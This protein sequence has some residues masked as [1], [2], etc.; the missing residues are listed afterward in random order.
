MTKINKHFTISLDIVDKLKKIDNASGLIEQLLTEHFKISAPIDEKVINKLKEFKEKKKELS[1]IKKELIHLKEESKLMVNLLRNK[2]KTQEEKDKL[3]YMIEEQIRKRRME[4]R[5]E[6][7]IEFKHSDKLK[8]P[9]F[10]KWLNSHE[11]YF[12]LK[13]GKK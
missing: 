4:L 12:N 1:F 6:Y 10:E 2:D 11:D 13:G 5:K 3:D 9:D 8:I 7:D